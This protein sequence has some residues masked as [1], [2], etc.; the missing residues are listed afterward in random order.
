MRRALRASVA[1][2]CIALTAAPPTLAETALRSG[3]PLDVRVAQ[4]E[5]FSRIEFRWQGAARMTAKRDGQTLTLRLSRDARPNL[6]DLQTV[7]L[8][9][10]KT[11]ETR[12]EGGALVVVLTLADGADAKVGDADG[13]N[14]V[15]L[16]EKRGD[17]APAAQA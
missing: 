8:R 13:A 3:A 2:A 14:F 5:Q 6:A 15:N 10:L 11:A 12:H 16:F 9:W 7:P 4:A 17:D 1:A